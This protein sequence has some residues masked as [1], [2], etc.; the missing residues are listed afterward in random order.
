[1]GAVV[2]RAEG[3]E[4]LVTNESKVVN[5]GQVTRRAVTHLRGTGEGGDSDGRN[6]HV[7]FGAK[8]EVTRP[9]AR[10]HANIEGVHVGFEG[11]RLEPMD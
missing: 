2:T 6:L 8:V 5:E 9:G 7:V 10:V 1:M 3:I 11:M 4:I